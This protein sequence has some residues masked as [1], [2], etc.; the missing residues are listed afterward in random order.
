M[1]R[2][3]EEAVLLASK[4]LKNPKPTRHTDVK[5]SLTTMPIRQRLIILL[6]FLFGF[7]V[8]IVLVVRALV[9]S[10]KVEDGTANAI[11]M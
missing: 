4:S 10:T 5:V 8:P 11:R 6:V 1:R 9:G 3:C 7:I 2:D